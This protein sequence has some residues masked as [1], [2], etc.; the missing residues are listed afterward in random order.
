MT[1]IPLTFPE[2]GLIAS[3]RAILGAGIALLLGDK[4]SGEQRQAVGWTL[5][6]VGVASSFPIIINVL[7]KRDEARD[8]ARLRSA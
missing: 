3:T 6:L 7:H 8:A 5:L 1:K 2:I 4:L